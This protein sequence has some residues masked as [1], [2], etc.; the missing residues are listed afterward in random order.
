MILLRQEPPEH[1]AV[2]G[3]AESR[4]SPKYQDDLTTKVQ[5]L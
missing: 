5:F 3:T 4:F 1:A 2:R